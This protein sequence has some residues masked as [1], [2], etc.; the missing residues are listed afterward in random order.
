[1]DLDRRQRSTIST[2]KTFAVHSIQEEETAKYSNTKIQPL[3]FQFNNC[4]HTINHVRSF[5]ILVSWSSE[6]K[7]WKIFQPI[8][9]SRSWFQKNVNLWKK[10]LFEI[11]TDLLF[12]VFKT[13]VIL[14]SFQNL[15]SEK[16]P[17]S[18]KRN[19]TIF[20]FNEW[21]NYFNSLQIWNR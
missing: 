10:I 8:L 19:Y 9:F 14:K 5:I 18:H 11:I 7:V 6:R 4:G 20:R 3:Q 15:F 1:M 13:F 12:V 2:V 21:K 17:I 16:S